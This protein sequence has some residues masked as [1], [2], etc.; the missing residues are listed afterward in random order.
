M[1]FIDLC[2]LGDPPSRIYFYVLH[3]TVT[4]TCN[5]REFY[6]RYL[7]NFIRLYFS[8]SILFEIKYYSL[9]ELKFLR[10]P[11]KIIRRAIFKAFLA[12]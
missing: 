9:E 7:N 10:L 6:L 4:L 12:K 11:S 2:I 8:V 5:G 1:K 3:N